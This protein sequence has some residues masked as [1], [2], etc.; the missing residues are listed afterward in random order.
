MPVKESPMIFRMCDIEELHAR[1][2]GEF[3][4]LQ[5]VTLFPMDTVK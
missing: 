3:P 2:K 1:K 4:L 5:K